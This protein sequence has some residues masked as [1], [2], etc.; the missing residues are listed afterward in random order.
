M[1][2]L[3]LIYIVIVISAIIWLAYDTGRNT[4]KAE[5]KEPPITASEEAAVYGAMGLSPRGL[6]LNKD[7]TD[8]TL[9]GK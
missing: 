3:N 7:G 9:E 8:R 1:S 2:R 4:E 6:H 5:Y